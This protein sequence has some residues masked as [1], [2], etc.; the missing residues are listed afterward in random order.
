MYLSWYRQPGPIVAHLDEDATEDVIG[1]RWDSSHEE[2]AL[3]IVAT[4]GASFQPVWRTTPIRAQWGSP[5]THLARSLDRLY[6][7]DSEGLVHLYDLADGHE[8]RAPLT[9]ARVHELCGRPNTLAEA[10]YR[11]QD[12]WRKMDHGV[13]L[14]RDG[15]AKPA[16][17]PPWC[18]ALRRTCDKPGDGVCGRIRKDGRLGAV[19]LEDGD[20]GVTLGGKSFQVGTINYGFYLTGYDPKTGAVRWDH[21]LPFTTDELHAD[22]H[23][24]VE[25][26]AGNVYGFYQ[27]KSGAWKLG[28]RSGRTG[29][30]L[31]QR[32][33]PRAVHGTTFSDMSI[34]AERLYVAIDWRL[35]VFDLSTGKSL[36]VVW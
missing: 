2:A 26:G 23:L 11:D 20:V 32:E 10:W 17:R 4:N 36:G 34:S 33:P 14:D 15:E 24:R 30:V 27:L 13:L 5:R 35:E 3:S 25:L 9:V 19:S 21:T 31:W 1:L 22:P 8:T 7:S 28:A 29:E 16:A 18:R 12:D 6:L